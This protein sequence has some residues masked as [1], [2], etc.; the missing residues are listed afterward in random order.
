MRV[1]LPE[2]SKLVTVCDVVLLLCILP[3]L[4]I[5][6]ALNVKIRRFLETP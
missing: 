4:L 2:V 1:D 5:Y 6:I 3:S